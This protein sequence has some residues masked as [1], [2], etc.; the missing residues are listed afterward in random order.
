LHHTKEQ[1]IRFVPKLFKKLICRFRRGKKSYRDIFQKQKLASRS[2]WSQRKVKPNEKRTDSNLRR[3]RTT[4]TLMLQVII[5][6]SKD[7]QDSFRGRKRRGGAE[8]ARG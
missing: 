4:S 8:G 6:Q 3:W 1:R 7:I 5:L 2:T